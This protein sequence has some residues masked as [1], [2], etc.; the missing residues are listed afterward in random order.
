MKIQR[1]FLGLGT[2][3]KFDD[4]ESERRHKEACKSALKSRLF[5]ATAGSTVVID[6]HGKN[7]TYHIQVLG[8]NVAFQFDED[9]FQLENPSTYDYNKDF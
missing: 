3:S 1:S 4:P 9:I 6:H 7:D 2:A 8:K 5:S